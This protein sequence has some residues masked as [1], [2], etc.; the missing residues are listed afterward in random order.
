MA[1]HDQTQVVHE[2]ADSWHHHTSAEGRPQHEHASVA[3]PHVLFHWFFLIVVSG[4]VVIVALFMYFGKMYNTTRQE[5]VETLQFYQDNAWPKVRD[6]EA[7]LGTDRPLSQFTY[8]AADKQ[9][10]TV[11]LP[12]EEAMNRVVQRY[13]PGTSAQGPQAGTTQPKQ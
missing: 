2:H 12:I 9:A 11:Q 3:N 1:G 6:S 13:R 4:V 8:H 5:R 10:H 7:A